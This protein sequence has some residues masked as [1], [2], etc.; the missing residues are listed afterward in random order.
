[1]GLNCVL[2][3]VVRL[4]HW[5]FVLFVVIAPFCS[6]PQLVVM[7]AALIPFVCFHWLLN[8]DVCCLTLLERWIRGCDAEESFFHNVVSPIYTAAV[9]GRGV[10]D[11]TLSCWIWGATIALWSV[12]V[13]RIARHPEWVRQTFLPPRK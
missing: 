2:A 6:K 3:N 13:C 4:I 5:L 8:S 1:M 7:H 12:S 11:E 9:P 10:S